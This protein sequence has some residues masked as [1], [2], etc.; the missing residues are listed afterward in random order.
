[1]HTRIVHDL[2]RSIEVFQEFNFHFLFEIGHFI[3]LYITMEN[4]E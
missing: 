2:I 1:M 3:S 4:S